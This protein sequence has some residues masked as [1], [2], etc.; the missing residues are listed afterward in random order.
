[1]GQV[2]VERFELDNLIEALGEL[3]SLIAKPV[4][5]SGSRAIEYSLNVASA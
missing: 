5:A 3:R 4:V 1:L 2:I